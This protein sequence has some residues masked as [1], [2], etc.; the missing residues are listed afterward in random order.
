MR[1]KSAFVTA[2]ALVAFAGCGEDDGSDSEPVFPAAKK[3]PAGLWDAPVRDLAEARRLCDAAQE[4]WPDA[5]AGHD[6]VTFEIPGTGSAL[7][8]VRQR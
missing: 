5:Y 3:N 6:Q 2:F 4:G 1:S 8:C 7:T